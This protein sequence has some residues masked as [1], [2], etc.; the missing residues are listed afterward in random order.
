MELETILYL[1]LSIV[2]VYLANALRREAVRRGG[3]LDSKTTL[4]AY[5]WKQALT[6]IFA[7]VALAAGLGATRWTGPLGSQVL[8]LLMVGCW[9]ANQRANA[10][11]WAVAAPPESQKSEAQDLGLWTKAVQD[12]QPRP[13]EAAFDALEET[14][15]NKAP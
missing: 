2:L 14:L 7:A 4:S 8:I 9:Y 6:V 15:K 1:L 11:S 5:K 3:L 12:S 13:T 10:A